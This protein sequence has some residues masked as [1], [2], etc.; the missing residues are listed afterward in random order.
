MKKIPVFLAFCLLIILQSCSVDDRRS[1]DENEN[2][3]NGVELLG[4]WQL[5]QYFEGGRQIAMN[6]CE[7]NETISFHKDKT[8][9]YVYYGDAQS[10]APC[11]ISVAG[12]GTWQYTAERKVLL[13]YSINEH[14]DIVPIYFK[15]SGNTL[16][17]TTDEAE[18]SYTE[19]YT[20]LH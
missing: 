6:S 20:R 5:Q 13:D 3:F 10:G 12:K 11:T 16:L 7:T 15:I 2:N 18:N 17:M 14:E 19:S 1:P 9:D 4:T 8:F